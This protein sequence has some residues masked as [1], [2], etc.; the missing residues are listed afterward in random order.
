MARDFLQPRHSHRSSSDV[1][2]DGV[3]LAAATT[4][5]AASCVLRLVR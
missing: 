3:P 2:D 5:T 1:D 4:V